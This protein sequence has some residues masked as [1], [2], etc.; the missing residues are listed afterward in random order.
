MESSGGDIDSLLQ[1]GT[2]APSIWMRINL[3]RFWCSAGRGGLQAFDHNGKLIW[4]FRDVHDSIQVDA[5]DIFGDGDVKIVSTNLRG[6]LNVLGRDG[7]KK[8]VLKTEHPAGRMRMSKPAGREMGTT[9]FV[10]SRDVVDK[11]P[12]SLLS[13]LSGDGSEKWSVNIPTQYK[14]DACSMSVAKSREWLAVG[15][16]GGAVHVIDT[17]DGHSIA[18]WYGLGTY[19]QVAWAK[20]AFAE[21]PRLV[22]GAG[23]RIDAYRVIK[24]D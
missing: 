11:R 3:T 10:T 9:I 21:E 1:F 23:D 6:E 16:Y 19:P 12:A 22:V 4:N 17:S 14:P 18:S 5:T 13:A 15:M 2:F 8:Q 24:L 20:D 7:V